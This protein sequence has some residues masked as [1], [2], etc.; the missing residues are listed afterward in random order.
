MPLVIHSNLKLNAFDYINSFTFFDDTQK[1]R[2]LFVQ[3]T[4]HFS[5]CFR[6]AFAWIANYQLVLN[7]TL[8]QAVCLDRHEYLIK[9]DSW[10][11]IVKEIERTNDDKDNT[12]FYHGHTLP[13]FRDDGLCKATI[14][15][16]FTIVWLPEEVFLIFLIPS[17]IGRMSKLIIRYCHFNHNN[18]HFP[19]EA[20]YHN[21]KS[22]SRFSRFDILPEKKRFAIN[23]HLFLLPNTLIALLHMIKAFSFTLVNVILVNYLEMNNKID[24]LLN[25][26]LVN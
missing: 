1:Q 24:S 17:F 10:S 4:Q 25:L 12:L 15:T 21:C 6:G 5:S 2:L 16:Q 7:A 11:L 9:K 18:S 20:P 23:I 8:K 3:R 19:L 14:S 13:C 26:F 22:Q